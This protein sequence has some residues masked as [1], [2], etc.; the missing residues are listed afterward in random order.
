[1]RNVNFVTEQADLQA[2]L[3]ALIGCVGPLK[4]LTA[5]WGDKANSVK[6]AKTVERL[7]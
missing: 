6:L 1:M 4:I 5:S 2:L 3:G 7:L